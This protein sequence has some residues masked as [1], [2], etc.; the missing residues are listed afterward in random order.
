M[1]NNKGFT[2]IEI[3]IASFIMGILSLALFGFMNTGAR[4]YSSVNATVKLQ[5]DTQ[6]AMSQIQEYVIDCDSAIAW[7]VTSGTLTV[8]NED[9]VEEHNFY[10]VDGDLTYSGTAGTGIMI[11][12]VTDFGVNFPNATGEV[13]H[14]DVTLGLEYYEKD[15]T[16]TQTFA[17][18]NNP[19]VTMTT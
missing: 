19:E 16:T 12:N 6:L 2:L 8:T 1:Q 13:S 9:P 5:Y 15:L 18:R 17:L 10:L 14:V 3:L 4:T 7:N 11:K